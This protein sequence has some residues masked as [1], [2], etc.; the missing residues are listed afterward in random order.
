MEITPQS[1]LKIFRD[2]QKELSD[3]PAYIHFFEL[4]GEDIRMTVQEG[5][6]C[7]REMN[8]AF[9]L[10]LKR[11]DFRVVRDPDFN[12]IHGIDHEYLIIMKNSHK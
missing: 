12:Y 7:S 8:K 11:N 3:N 9:K 6:P 10:I 5:S 1:L 4:D 2:N